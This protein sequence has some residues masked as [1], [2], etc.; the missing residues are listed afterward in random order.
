MFRRMILFVAV[1]AFAASAMTQAALYDSVKTR[2]AAKHSV[3]VDD[4]TIRSETLNASEVSA[5]VPVLQGQLAY[6]VTSGGSLVADGSVK[7]YK[8]SATSDYSFDP[9]DLDDELIAT[10]TSWLMNGSNHSGIEYYPKGSWSVN[11]YSN[12]GTVKIL[13]TLCV[14]LDPVADTSSEVTV[15]IIKRGTD[16]VAITDEQ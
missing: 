4:V 2:L 12:G 3:T 6:I 7:I 14:K 1:L 10:A 13:K 8:V 9:P 16:P 5:S 11:V 15:T